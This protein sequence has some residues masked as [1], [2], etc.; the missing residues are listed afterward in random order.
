VTFTVCGATILDG[1][2][3][4]P[5]V[6]N[7]TVAEDRIV[8]VGSLTSGEVVDGDGLFLTPG[9]IDCHCHDDLASLRDPSRPEKVA[10]GV[11][12]VVVG[13]CGFS[14]FPCSPSSR[15]QLRQ[16]AGGLLGRLGESEV[17][18]DYASYRQAN[19]S[20]VRVESLVGHGPL[21]LQ[22][23][24]WESRPASASEL[25]LMC[26]LLA[27]QLDQ[28]ACGL[29]LGL[30]YP[31]SAFADLDELVAL[32][33]VAKSR[34][35][36]VTAHIRSYE[37]KLVEATQEFLSVL[38]LSGARGV[39][40]HLQAAGRPNWGLVAQALE[41][42]EAA[43]VDVVCDMYPYLA[44]SS[45]AL[46]LLPPSELASGVSAL[47]AR[48]AEPAYRLLLRNRVMSA[49]VDE[50]GWQSKVALIGWESV[51][52]AGVSALSLKSLEGKTLASAGEDPFDVLIRLVMEDDGASAVILF[53]LSEPDL[54]TVFQNPLSMVGSD[55]IP[56][57]EGRP[58]P[59]A[60]GA[61]P[62]FW[63]KVC[64]QD[65]WL[66]APEAIAKMT[67]RSAIA[68]GLNDRGVIRPGS[69]A[70]LVLFDPSF[71]D[72]ATFEDPRQLASGTK[73]VWIGGNPV[74]A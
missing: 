29:S 17:F 1:S 65:R 57:F 9:F 32:A 7:V 27:T 35:K 30:V 11:T 13:N 55:G 8:S 31:P 63:Q 28:G 34:G 69:L 23:M 49:E 72:Q 52:I 10:Q 61:F 51:L 59:R 40:S 16:H 56:R 19:R 24:G 64:Q 48:L 42:M 39:L 15:E 53:Q 47:Q 41:A 38:R 26:D 2:G 36:P 43:E 46:Q 4:E 67:S 66:A 20:V 33:K 73:Q 37:S 68:F 45:Y 14:L 22:A 44:G 74:L 6:S 62:R 18:S 3:G 50:N 25:A 21:R 12:T 5:F 70:D 58:H 54:R 60:F 71:R